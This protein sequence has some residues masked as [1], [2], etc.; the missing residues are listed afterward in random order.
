MIP[1]LLAD[2][3]GDSRA[4]FTALGALA[5]IGSVFFLLAKKPARPRREA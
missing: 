5:A 2:A 4:G 3:T 1:G